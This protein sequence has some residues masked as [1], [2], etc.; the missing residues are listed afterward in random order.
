MNFIWDENKNALNKKK[1]GISFETAAYVF[2]DQ[3]RIQIYDELHSIDEERWQVIGCV[4]GAV[5]FVVETEISED[6][7]RIISARPA[8]GAE[9][10]AYYGQDN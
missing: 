10:K 5:L 9:R 8:T 7:I 2:K 6:L 4:S 3:M 1:H